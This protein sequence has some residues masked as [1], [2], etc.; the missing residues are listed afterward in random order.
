MGLL[1]TILALLAVIV[2]AAGGAYLYMRTRNDTSLFTPRVRRLAFIERAY[3]DGGRKLLLV[4]RDDVEHLI[5]VGGPIDLVV[6]TGIRPERLVNSAETEDSLADA[7]QSH[8]EAAARIWQRPDIALPQAK[9]GSATA[10]PSL[11]LSPDA[12]ASAETNAENTLELTP[13]HEVKAAS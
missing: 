6:E 9:I 8:S 10:G 13:R 1:F 4:R 11:S 12:K 7:V 5:L 2:I 3:L